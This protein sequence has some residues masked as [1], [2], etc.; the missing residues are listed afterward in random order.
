M[1]LCTGVSGFEGADAGLSE[2][3]V[4][5]GPMR[6]LRS[7]RSQVM[8]ARRRSAAQ[9]RGAST[10]DPPLLCS[11]EQGF[12]SLQRRRLPRFRRATSSSPLSCND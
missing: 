5:N 11:T 2:N 4:P 7:S 6:R 12:S 1:N 3:V 10:L 8:A 9:R